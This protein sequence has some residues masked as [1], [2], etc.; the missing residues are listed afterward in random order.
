MDEVEYYFDPEKNAFLKEKRGISFEEIILLIEEGY[1]LK[2][3]KHPNFVKYP[4][5]EFYVIDVE[6]Y[7]YLVPFVR[8]GN[9]IYLKTIFPS[10]KATQALLG[11]RRR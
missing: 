8:D 7:A 5:Q 2:V 6:G 11:K 4:H 3:M 9:K 1:L 10:R